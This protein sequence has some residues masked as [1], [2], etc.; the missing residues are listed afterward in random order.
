MRSIVW[1]TVS[2]ERERTEPN[3]VEVMRSPS[4]IEREA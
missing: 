1:H 2:I 3:P 4:E